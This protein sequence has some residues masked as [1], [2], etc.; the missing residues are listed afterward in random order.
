MHRVICHEHQNPRGKP[1][2]WNKD[3][4]LKWAATTQGWDKETTTHNILERYDISQINGSD[5]DPLS[6][7]LYFFPPELTMNGVGTKQ[8]L[9]LSGEDVQWINKNYATG[10]PQTAEQFYQKVYN[11]SLQK[12]LE[13]SGV[14]EQKIIGGTDPNKID[15]NTV[16]QN[17]TL[18]KA[19]K[20]ALGIFLVI[21]FILILKR[22]LKRAPQPRVMFFKQRY[23]FL[24]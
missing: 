6:V 3:V 22:L 5:F 4:V 9:R 2:E 19:G 1:I 21:A 14:I 23:N 17:G 12:A 7:M 10:A 15:F 13:M 24:A 11:I 16:L 20:I 18:K 8:N